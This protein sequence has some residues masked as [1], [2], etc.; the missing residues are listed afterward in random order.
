MCIRDRYKN[1]SNYFDVIYPYHRV[2]NRHCDNLMK[3]IDTYEEYTIKSGNSK[4]FGGG[5]FI[6][7]V[8]FLKKFPFIDVGVYGP[9]DVIFN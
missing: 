7:R 8:F 9:E 5:I 4:Y 3:T 2:Y 1:V 6:T